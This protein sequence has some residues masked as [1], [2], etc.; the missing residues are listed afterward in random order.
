MVRTTA[1]NNV[2]NAFVDKVPGVTVG[3]TIIAADQNMRQ[4]ELANAIELAGLTLSG[5]DDEQLYKAIVALS[6]GVAEPVFSIIK[7]TVGNAWPAVRVDDA[8]HDITVAHWPL[9]VPALRAHKLESDSVTDFAISLAAGVATFANAAPENRML[10]A[11]AEEILVHGGYASWLALNLGGTD[12]AITNV[13]PGAHTVTVAGPPGNGNYTAIVYPYRVAGAATARLRRMSARALVGAD[14]Q[15][16]TGAGELL[17]GLRRRDRAQGRQLGFVSTGGTY[18]GAIAEVILRGTAGDDTPTA[19]VMNIATGGSA[20]A[21]RARG[22]FGN[23]L[24]DGIND[25]PRTGL[26]TDPRTQAAY[27][28][29]WGGIY[30]P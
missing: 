27:A 1:P 10:A 8:D 28:Y 9:L 25:T 11:L 13:T 2:A 30:T 3:T 12:Y 26:T 18:T 24:T 20:A 4:E 22:N 16:G 15:A 5:A 29:I 7:K 14:D 19:S 23:P 6:H 21:I 17:A